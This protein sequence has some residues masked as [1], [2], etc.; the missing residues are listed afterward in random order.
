MNIFIR[1]GNSDV[2]DLLIKHG[3]TIKN[4]ELNVNDG[5]PILHWAAEKGD[6]FKT[7][8]KNIVQ[9]KRLII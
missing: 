9:I 3:A 5:K 7:G 1:L 4:L 2:A 8:R 6:F